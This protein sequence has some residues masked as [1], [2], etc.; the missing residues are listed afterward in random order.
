MPTAPEIIVDL[1]RE[2]ELYHLFARAMGYPTKADVQIKLDKLL[3]NDGVEEEKI[4]E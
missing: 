2:L 1:A 4:E 3:Q